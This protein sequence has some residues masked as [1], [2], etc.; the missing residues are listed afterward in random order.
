VIE[1]K[2]GSWRIKV[3]L[4]GK[5]DTREA[6]V[7]VATISTGVDMVWILQEYICC[8]YLRRPYEGTRKSELSKR[9]IT[10]QNAFRNTLEIDAL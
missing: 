1:I 8:S 9:V 3:K 5:K 10:F 7:K 6:K 2:R 4:G